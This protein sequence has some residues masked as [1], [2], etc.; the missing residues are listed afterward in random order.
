METGYKISDAMTR[1][2]VTVGK[3][4]TIVECAQIMKKKHVGSLIIEDKGELVGII[5]EQDIARKV[6]AA[7]LDPMTTKVEDIMVTNLITIDP[8][9]DIYDSL[10]LM[11]NHNIR[12]LPVLVDGE[13]VGYLTIKDILKIEPQL[14]EIIAERFELREEDRKPI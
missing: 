10:V 13:L 4:T 7:E 14:F 3:E 1:R 5:T 9:S 6:V 2:P 12:H 11:R 8:D